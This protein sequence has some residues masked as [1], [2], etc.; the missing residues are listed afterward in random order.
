M[1]VRFLPAPLIHIITMEKIKH[2]I[3]RS[4]SAG[5]R[6]YYFDANKDSKGHPYLVITEIHKDGAP[7]EKKRQKLFIHSDNMDEFI[8]TL[9]EMAGQIKDMESPGE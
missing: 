2:I 3:S 5:T 6:V 1:Q 7:G 4:I 8:S 9:T